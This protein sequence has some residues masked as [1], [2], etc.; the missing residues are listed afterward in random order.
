VGQGGARGNRSRTPGGLAVARTDDEY[1][2]YHTSPTHKGVLV[3]RVLDASRTAVPGTEV[4]LMIVLWQLGQDG[5]LG[6]ALGT[7]SPR[8]RTRPRSKSDIPDN[9]KSMRLQKTAERMGSQ[10][11]GLAE[12]TTHLPRPL[13]PVRG[14]QDVFP[15]QRVD[16]GA[17]RYQHGISTATGI[18]AVEPD[19]ESSRLV[20]LTS[21]VRVFGRVELS[22]GLGLGQLRHG[23]VAIRLGSSEEDERSKESWGWGWG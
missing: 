17:K 4:T 10:C 21:S 15:D 7:I 13:R 11:V 6:L 18:T 3:R 19:P 8:P 20:S 22:S 9:P 2:E 1:H 16:Y 14:H 12:T 23:G 5:L